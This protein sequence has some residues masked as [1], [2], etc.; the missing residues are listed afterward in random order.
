M[1]SCHRH[2]RA[3]ELS[4]DDMRDDINWK[5]PGLELARVLLIEF[6]D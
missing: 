1:V 6:L 4:E 5:S 2:R 3:R